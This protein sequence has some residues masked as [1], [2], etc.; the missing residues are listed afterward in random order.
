M[1]PYWKLAVLV[2][3]LVP[4]NWVRRW[5]RDL[6]TAEGNSIFPAQTGGDFLIVPQRRIRL[7]FASGS[8]DNEPAN[9]LH[10]IRGDTVNVT[11]PKGKAG[12]NAYHEDER[13]VLH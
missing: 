3:R 8:A 11:L 7:E 5:G 13:N 2:R 9:T 1:K 4:D 10:L 6:L 12:F